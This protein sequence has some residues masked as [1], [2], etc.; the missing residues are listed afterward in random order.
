MQRDR[1][2]VSLFLLF[3][4]R[5]KFLICPLTHI[6]RSLSSPPSSVLFSAVLLIRVCPSCSLPAVED[7]RTCLAATGRQRDL[8]DAFRAQLRQ[9]LLLPGAATTDILTHYIA[10]IKVRHYAY[11]A[12]APNPAG[13]FIRFRL[14]GR[15]FIIDQN[16]ATS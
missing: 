3:G 15:L 9:R 10:T 7:L 13:R 4:F 1:R 11:R 6:L 8:V 12:V 14:L 5:K 2:V 16:R